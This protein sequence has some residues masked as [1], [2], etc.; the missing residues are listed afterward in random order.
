M[1]VIAPRFVKPRVKNKKNDI[2]DADAIAEAANSTMSHSV[3]VT[4]PAQQGLSIIYQLQGLPVRPT[5]ANSQRA[6]WPP[7]Q[8]TKP[9]ALVCKQINRFSSSVQSGFVGCA[10][11][12]P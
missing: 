6:A 5:R 2:A 9:V 12:H 1:R 4:S 7:A 10:I 3:E 8:P 11:T